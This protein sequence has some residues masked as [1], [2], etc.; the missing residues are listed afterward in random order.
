IQLYTPNPVEGKSL[1]NYKFGLDWGEKSQDLPYP[2]YFTSTNGGAY[3]S[4]VPVRGAPVEFRKVYF[5]GQLVD[6]QYGYTTGSGCD[7]RSFYAYFACSKPVDQTAIAS[8]EGSIPSGKLINSRNENFAHSDHATVREWEEIEIFSCGSGSGECKENAYISL[9][10]EDPES[11]NDRVQ[12]NLS[13]DPF[14]GESC[15]P[16]KDVLAISGCGV[17]HQYMQI[18]SGELSGYCGSVIKIKNE[19]IVYRDITDEI[20]DYEVDPSDTSDCICSG[21]I[22]AFSGSG[23]SLKT[24]KATA[25]EY[26]GYCGTVVEIPNVSGS[27]IDID[28]QASGCLNVSESST[29][30]TKTVT[31]SINRPQILS[32]LGYHETG[33]RILVNNAVDAEGE[34][35]NPTGFGNFS[36]CDLV[37]LARCPSESDNGWLYPYPSGFVAS[38]NC[39][40][41]P[42]GACCY[43]GECSIV[44]ED[45]CDG[46][47]WGNGTEC[48]D[49]ASSFSNAFPTNISETISDLCATGVGCFYNITDD[50]YDCELS[51]SKR[52]YYELI[53]S[54]AD[55]QWDQNDDRFDA[56]PRGDGIDH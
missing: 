51:L 47:Y 12:Y 30:S 43:S 11:W 9:N 20:E 40:S 25:G 27:G 24:I 36:S 28:F 4:P 38:G 23:I 6:D 53:Y 39:C 5:R 18:T 29:S 48:D 46:Y 26:S 17:S 19:D 55:Y 13:G 33:V 2:P 34:P 35:T 21:S 16:C 41:V 3:D 31:Y 45:S 54:N 22:L 42:S 8:G 44:G 10:Q 50:E 56:E 32:C 49:L 7:E 15:L 1:D 37:M 14:T 52:E